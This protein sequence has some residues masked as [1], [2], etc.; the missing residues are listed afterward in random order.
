MMFKLCRKISVLARILFFFS[1]RWFIVHISFVQFV[2]ETFSNNNIGPMPPPELLLSDGGHV[3]NLALLPL[4]KKRVKKIVV[5]DG[6]HKEDEE[7]YGNSLLNALML[8]RTYLECSF[9]SKDGGD[10]TSYMLD[11]FQDPKKGKLPR[12]FK[13]VHALFYYWFVILE[14]NKKKQTVSSYSSI[15]VF[16]QQF[17]L[18]ERIKL[19]GQLSLKVTSV[20][21]LNG[22]RQSHPE[23]R[24]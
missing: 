13:F 10:V 14:K 16:L 12:V 18:K 3:E 15:F 20:L 8:A 5:V 21:A 17:S 19:I 11:A 22:F 1:L 2:R 9:L 6:G 7:H 23:M 24:V 4:L